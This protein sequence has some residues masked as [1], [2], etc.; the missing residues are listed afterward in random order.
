MTKLFLFITMASIFSTGLKLQA[1]SFKV[2]TKQVGSV[3]I[4]FVHNADADESSYQL[5]ASFSEIERLAPIRPELLLS[6][7]PADLRNLSLEE[8]N[9]VY[10]RISA[11]PMP[12]GDYDG[13]IL[14]KAAVFSALKKRL[15][16]VTFVYPKFAE[17]VK[18]ICQRDAEDCFMEFIWKGKRFSA[19]NEFGQ[20]LV[21]TIFN[22]ITASS[23]FSVDF[24]KSKF[25]EKVFDFG[26]NIV[27]GVVTLFPM[28]TYCG[29]SQIDTRRESIIADANF[30]DDFGLPSYVGLRDEVVTRKGLGITEEYRMLRPGLYMGKVYSNKIFL[31]NVVLERTGTQPISQ[32]MKTETK[33]H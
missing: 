2:I 28:N 30:G 20:L 21:K 14:Q 26:E 11:G 8:F 6:V 18:M 13:F 22:P 12:D 3:V 9:Q 31:F 16:R 4:P 25:L 17:L 19:P 27:N 33:C 23:K 32:L 10:A 1:A 7:K 24:F 29:I 15:L 5:K